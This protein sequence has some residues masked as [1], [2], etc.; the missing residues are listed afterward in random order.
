MIILDN[1]E[2]KYI[3]LKLYI[4]SITFNTLKSVQQWT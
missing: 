3:M 4:W 1:A 2:L